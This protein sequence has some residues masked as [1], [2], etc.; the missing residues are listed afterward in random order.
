[1]DI[2]NEIPSYEVTSLTDKD[3]GSLRN[4][5]KER[6]VVSSNA[7]QYES[8]CTGSDYDSEHTDTSSI[9]K[10]IPNRT[11]LRETMSN[12]DRSATT[13]K[14]D[15]V[16]RSLPNRVPQREPGQKP[17]SNF[18][19]VIKANTPSQSNS[20]KDADGALSTLL[21]CKQLNTHLE[22]Y[23]QFAQSPKT[24]R[25]STSET[26]NK[27]PTTTTT[28]LSQSPKPETRNSVCAAVPVKDET[29]EEKNVAE[30]LMEDDDDECKVLNPYLLNG[31]VIRVRDGNFWVVLTAD[32][33]SKKFSLVANPK[34]GTTITFQVS[35]YGFVWL[36]V[37]VC[38]VK[39]N[40]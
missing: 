2:E 17:S 23:V 9:Y 31:N 20:N 7:I 38:W 13:K 6:T 11:P 1:M 19:T 30:K 33:A 15:S 5:E 4:G 40:V 34:E 18:F 22:Y 39:C 21:M 12:G 16:E 14:T 35:G 27:P 29:R 32:L 26:Q 24:S 8:E 10:T 3:R 28:T 37:Y 36:C 25:S